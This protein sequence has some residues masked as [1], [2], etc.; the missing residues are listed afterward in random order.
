MSAVKSKFPDRHI[1]SSEHLFNKPL[2]CATK[3][4][5]FKQWSMYILEI[6]MI[7]G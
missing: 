3:D 7:S 1:F 5:M 6:S 2:N 4:M